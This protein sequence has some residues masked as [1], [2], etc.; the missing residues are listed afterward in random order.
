MGDVPHWL[1]PKR[2]RL[3]ACSAWT[4]FLRAGEPAK[5]LVSACRAA[6][7]GREAGLAP[8]AGMQATTGHFFR[9]VE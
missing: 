5:A 6:L 2:G 3:C 7:D 9:G 8:F 4:L 1:L